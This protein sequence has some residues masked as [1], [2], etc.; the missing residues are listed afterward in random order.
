MPRVRSIARTVTLR[1]VEWSKSAIFAG[2]WKSKIERSIDVTVTIITWIRYHLRLARSEQRYVYPVY[3]CALSIPPRKPKSNQR[4]HRDI[5]ATFNAPL[6]DWI[7]QLYGKRKNRR[8]FVE[9]PATSPYRLRSLRI[10]VRANRNET[11]KVVARP[12]P[13]PFLR[14]RPSRRR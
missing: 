8:K 1:I 13:R 2:I 10:V 5:V 11:A 3:F 6:C 14:A 12:R 9:S 7:G 4:S